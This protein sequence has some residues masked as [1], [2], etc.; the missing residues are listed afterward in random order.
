MQVVVAETAAVGKCSV[1]SVMLV[2]VEAG[3]AVDLS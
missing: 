2:C 3:V 1:D